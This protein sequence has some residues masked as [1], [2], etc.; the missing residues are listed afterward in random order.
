M[1][2]DEEQEFGT[3]IQVATDTGLGKTILNRTD[4]QKIENECRMVKTKIKFRPWGTD[5][6][7]PIRGRNKVQL[8]AQAGAT[9]TT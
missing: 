9:I 8:R 7:L 3:R 4:W 2:G 1:N 6:K 5:Q